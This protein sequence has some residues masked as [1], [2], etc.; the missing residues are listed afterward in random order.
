MSDR[1]YFPGEFKCAYCKKNLDQP[2]EYGQELTL[3]SGDSIDLKCPKCGAVWKFWAS[4][5]LFHKLVKGGQFN[6]NLSARVVIKDFNGWN[7]EKKHVHHEG[8]QKLCHERE[9]WWCAF[10]VNIGREQDGRGDN[11]E[12]PVA[13]LKKLSPDTFV[14]LPLSTKKRLEKFQSKVTYGILV[15]FALLDQVRVLD[16]KRLLRKIGSVDQEEFEAMRNKLKEFL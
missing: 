6:N 7:K 8:K 2:D 15:N 4:T 9:I 5:Q 1:Y 3:A 12:R 16:T 10:G 11:F 13:I 14:A